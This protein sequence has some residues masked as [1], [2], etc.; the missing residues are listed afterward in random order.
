MRIQA[1]DSLRGIAALAVLFHHYVFLYSVKFEL[2]TNF[3]KTEDINLSL[4][5]YGVE[6]FFIISGFVISI[7]IERSKDIPSFL[8][9][10]FSRLYPTFIFCLLLTSISLILLS[11]TND[12]S[13]QQ[14][15][16]NATMIPLFFWIK[17]I[18]GSY[19]TLM[20]ELFFYLWIAIF[21]SWSKEIKIRP[22]VVIYS[23]YVILTLM[24]LFIELPQKLQYLL[25]YPHLQQFL[26]G[27]ILYKIWSLNNSRATR[28][29][30]IL[31]FLFYASHLIM[32]LS[33]SGR[34]NLI[35]ALMIGFYLAIFIL[36]LQNR[37]KILEN[38]YLIKLGV[39]SYSLYLIHQQIGYLTISFL[40]EHYFPTS[41]AILITSLFVIAL[42]FIINK[43]IEV[44]SNRFVKNHLNSL[45]KISK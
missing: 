30:Y 29:L 43:Y 12:I 3:F 31:L 22:L 19:W 14:F 44:P 13:I 39:L 37:L 27:I 17:P 16:G 10:R 9:S 21:F 23:C 15:I 40:R 4:G 42:A 45:R 33:N 28:P 2:D 25:L 24:Q 35:S 6:L 8:I 32:S 5:R 11:S 26:S 38:K 1:I 41:I 18:D 36:L 34:L 20:Y 7:S